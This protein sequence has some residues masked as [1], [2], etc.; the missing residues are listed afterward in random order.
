[1]PLG[2][3]GNYHG[4]VRARVKRAFHLGHAVGLYDVHV[5]AVVAP[6]VP[7]HGRVAC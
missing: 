5:A 6:V 4:M 7:C 2:A 1:M 3:K